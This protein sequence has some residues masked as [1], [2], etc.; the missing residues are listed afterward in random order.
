MQTSSRLRT[1]ARIV[2]AVRRASHSSFDSICLSKRL[3]GLIDVLTE[4][5]VGTTTTTDV[6]SQSWLLSTCLAS[7]QVPTAQKMFARRSRPISHFNLM[8]RVPLFG[9][10]DDPR[11]QYIV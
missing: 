11:R 7:I 5:A 9:V 6:I 4:E 8:V 10:G 3:M 1:A 2:G